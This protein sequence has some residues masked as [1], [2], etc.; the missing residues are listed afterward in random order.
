MG[1]TIVALVVAGVMAMS[2]PSAELPSSLLITR[3][4]A[5]VGGGTVFTAPPAPTVAALLLP[6]ALA[7]PTG[8]TGARLSAIPD[9]L[10]ND[11]PASRYRMRV[12]VRGRTGLASV[13]GPLA[14]AWSENGYWYE[15]STTRLGLRQLIDLAGALE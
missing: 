9:S 4:N 13:D 10:L 14:I 2:Q 11:Q 3:E 5:K 1:A 12:V 8:T 6:P 7:L 15:L